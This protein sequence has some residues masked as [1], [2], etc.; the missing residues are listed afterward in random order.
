MHRWSKLFIPTLREAPSDA[1]VASHKFLLRAG[2][3][4]QLGA[5][6]Y[7]YLFLG[8][9]SIQKI[10]AIVREEMDRIGQEFL[11]PALLPA[12]LWQQSGRW[13]TMG[14]NMFRLQDRKGA[15]LC[16]GMTHEE[17]MTDIA[18]KELRS[19]KQLPQIWY[20]I[21]TKFRDEPRPKAGLLRVRQFLMKDS[22]SFDIDQDGL[23]RSYNLHDAAYCA[24]FTRCGL[25]FVA[26]EADSGAMGGSQ[27]QEF[28]V[29]TEAGE[30]L[31]ASNV[32]TGYA[33]NI[34]KATSR[35]APIDDLQPT[36]DGQPEL[37]HT[38]GVAAIA[39]VAAFFGILPAQDI[40]CVAYMAEVRD[41]AGKSAWKPVAAFL[42]GDHS[43]NET[44]L[45]GTVQGVELRTMNGD[46]L[47][48]WLQGPAGYLGPVGLAA[49]KT[50]TD[51]GLL[52]VVDS[53]LEGRRNLVCGANK[54]DYHFRNV[55]PGRDFDWTALADIRNANEGEDA[56]N[57]PEGVAAPLRIGKAVEIGHIFKLG[58]R[59]A[60]ALGARV[61]DQNGKEKMPIMGCYGIGIERILTAAIEQSA[62][63]G[64]DPN[65]PWLPR[66]IAPFE[67][68]VTI[69]NVRDEA[70]LAAGEHLANQLEAAGFDVLLDDRDERAGVKFKDADLVGIPLRINVGKKVAD[71][72]VE[73]VDRATGTTQDVAL[74]AVAAHVSAL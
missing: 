5:G 17:V 39:D 29:Y 38:P 45:L 44:K 18:R 3:V 67:V 48:Q 43:V 53:A 71:G 15:D 12:D 25:E 9:R 59:Y 23:D 28:M 36:G 64:T 49:A 16:L 65:G 21:Q 6:I 66:S 14:Q 54:L 4:R 69:T 19:Y 40:K 52:V 24:I 61:L 47:A 37:V 72:F 26:V 46:E 32:E 34:E 60:E 7:S 42:R 62:T 1:E 33:A 56:P 2:Y 31:I 10:T 11:L 50:I 13:T 27:S 20:Q 73:V 55:C 51:A 22:Y 57:A 35:L 63:R 30:D 8:Q 70:L 74:D 58:Y 68:V 41:A